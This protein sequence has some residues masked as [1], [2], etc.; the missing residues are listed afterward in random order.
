MRPGREV[1]RVTV[2]ASPAEYREIFAHRLRDANLDTQRF[3]D[4]Q[5][6]EKGTYDYTQYEPDAPGL[7]G[8]Y[9]VYGGAGAG[10]D[11]GWI[12]VD[13]DVDDYDGDRAPG[14]IPETLT[15]ASSH[16]DGDSG[17]HFYVALPTGTKDALKEAFGTANPSPSWGEVRVHNQY[18]VGPG[19][20]L[21][22][23]SK[24]WCDDCVDPD[25]G[26]Y[27][28]ACDAPI[29]QLETE[30]FIAAIKEGTPNCTGDDR[31]Q[32]VTDAYDDFNPE[33][34]EPEVTSADETTDD[35]RDVFAALDR[36]DAR[37]VAADTIVYRW[38]H[39]ATTS[40]NY[41]A[42]V[43]TW[44]PD[45]NGTANIVDD[46]IWQD[47]GGNGYGGPVVMAL[48]DTGELSHRNASPQAARGELFSV[49]VERLREMGYPIPEHEDGHDDTDSE[50]VPVLPATDQLQDATSGWDWRHATDDARDLSIKAARDRTTNAIA[51]AYDQHYQVLVEALPTMGKSY[52]AV[53]AAAETGQQV[54]IL[55]GCGRKEQYQQFRD[56]ADEH[57][58]S[59]YTLPAFTHDCDTANGEHGAEWR[60][61]VMDWYRRGATPKEIHLLAESVLGRPLPCQEHEGQEC[62]YM[63]KWQ[64]N[65]DK[66]DI[67]IG[68]Y[69][70]AHNQ[71]VTQG[72]TV[73]FDEFPGG[74][75]ETVLSGRV[76]RA[77]SYWLSQH[78][79][80][81]FD[82]YTDLLENR[83][84][85]QRR[86]DALAWFLDR[87]LDADETHVFDDPSA[88]AAAPLAVFALL[89]AADLEN[90][91]EVADL[92]DVGTAVRNR[93]D[94]T[95]T[96]LRPPA[97]DYASGVVALDGTPTTEMWET[98][99]DTRLNHRP[100]LSDAE[101]AEYIRDALNLHLVR[102][103]DAVKSYSAGE[104]EIA[105]RVSLAEDTALLEGIADHHGQ[106][107]AVITTARAEHVYDDEGVLNLASATKHYGNVLGSNEFDDT[108]LG[109]VL[110]SRNFGP[111]YVK[112][113]GRTSARPSSRPSRPPRTTSPRP[114]TAA[115]GTRFGPICA[116][117]RP[118]RRRCA[119]VVTVGARSSTSTPTRSPSGCRSPG[120]VASSRHGVM[121]CGQ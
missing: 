65:F 107:P 16:T 61:R 67:L 85:D 87:D 46:R 96:I 24:E 91:V 88:H 33:D 52:G 36:I 21:D 64:V 7:S 27:R 42:F 102:T 15:V 76:E 12:F 99:L 23:C 110:G 63:G 62:K 50:H 38:N 37:R 66:Y 41:R 39:A 60:E 45:A 121:G 115:W 100:V 29:A 51:D 84:D 57:G 119:S 22:G 20:Q 120:R 54:T 56:W 2:V 113:W 55:T 1:R 104:T 81:P 90:S 105:N 89:S 108:R 114:I 18:C 116:S 101:R 92:D 35:I 103:T 3:I 25:S 9:G 72:R 95:L 30:E 98:A 118:C 112:K 31:G 8:N 68:Y 44:G 74:A 34:Y 82:D 32:T 40:G 86:A 43:P 109:A 59:R 19:S 106:R 117:T 69:A 94:G 4:V 53:K 71:K 77:V 28:L 58:L 49:G 97:L 6:G 79:A 17:G 70:H 11:T 73:V 80:V 10:D 111:N 13:L 47:T 14:W 48:I 78:D 75:Y 26:Y 93:A 83:S 5:D